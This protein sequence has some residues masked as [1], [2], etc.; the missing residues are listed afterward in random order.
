MVSIYAHPCVNIQEQ[1]FSYHLTGTEDYLMF[2]WL[3]ALATNQKTAKNTPIYQPMSER[4]TTLCKLAYTYFSLDVYSI[5]QPSTKIRNYNWTY[6]LPP[7]T[8]GILKESGYWVQSTSSGW[9]IVYQSIIILTNTSL[10]W[11]LSHY[12]KKTNFYLLSTFFP[13]SFLI[14]YITFQDYTYC[15]RKCPSRCHQ[16]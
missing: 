7:I 5:R 6:R 12:F 16:T 9:F 8:S 3:V 13:T 2:A 4:Y 11:L 15:C 14:G 1:L 10:S